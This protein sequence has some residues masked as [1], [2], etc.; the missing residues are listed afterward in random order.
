[1]DPNLIGYLY[2]K[3]K[4]GHR[5]VQREDLVKTQGENRHSQAKEGDLRRNLP[6]DILI[7]DF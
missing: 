5:E 7:S 6:S 2:K 3:R 4:L 1:M